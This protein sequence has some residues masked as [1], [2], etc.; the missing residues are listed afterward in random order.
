MKKTL[1]LLACFGILSACSCKKKQVEPAFQNSFSCKING[2]DWKPEGGTNATGGINTQEISIGKFFGN[3]RIFIDALKRIIDEKTG[4]RV[5]FEG[6]RLTIDLEIK[7]RILNGDGSNLF[8]NFNNECNYY[9]SDSIPTNRLAVTEIDTTN[10]II[11]GNFNFEVKS[12][13]CIEILKITD[14]N[15]R[16]KY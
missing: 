3:K 11:K 2:V 9:Y 1:W 8:Y 4:N 14:G 15:F 10:N 5:V 13:R 7:E 16:L 12:P 6:V